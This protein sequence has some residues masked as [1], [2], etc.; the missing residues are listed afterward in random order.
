MRSGSFV[1]FFQLAHSFSMFNSQLTQSFRVFEL[2]NRSHR[3]STSRW[4]RL[5]RRE[6]KISLRILN[7]VVRD[8]VTGKFVRGFDSRPSIQKASTCTR[9]GGI[10]VRQLVNDGANVNGLG[11]DA[12]RRRLVAFAET[13]ILAV[14]EIIDTAPFLRRS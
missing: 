4:I 2:T 10:V 13:L 6:I 7:A 9:A 11:V 8:S 1:G 3:I 12:T 14:F 5:Q